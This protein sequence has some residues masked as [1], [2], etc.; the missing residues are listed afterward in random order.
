MTRQE[1]LDRL[2]QA[3]G[4]YRGNWSTKR[5]E[6]EAYTSV[7]HYSF[8]GKQLKDGGYPLACTGIVIEY[9]DHNGIGVYLEQ[10]AGNVDDDIAEI[11]RRA[12]GRG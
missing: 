6:H 2:I 11:L 10:Q 9:P 3:G 7:H 4:M 8:Y 5:W 1:F 12:E